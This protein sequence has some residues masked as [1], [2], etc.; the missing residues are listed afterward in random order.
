MSLE[1]INR[2]HIFI[3]A[4]GQKTVGNPK[5][6]IGWGIV[7]FIDVLGFSAEVLSSWSEEE[8]S[9]LARIRRIK[10]AASRIPDAGMVANFP[11]KAQT[12]YSESEYRARVHTVSDSIVVCSALPPNLKDLYNIT[13]ALSVVSY[14]IQM[15]WIA[16]IHEGYTIRG[17]IELSKIYWSETE[18][19]GPAFVSA[20]CLESKI[21]HESRVIL[22]PLLLHN[23]LKKINDDWSDWPSSKWLSVSHDDLIEISPHHLKDDLNAN[24]EGLEKLQ[25]NAGRN[26]EKYNHI[27]EILRAGCFR[28]ASIEDL[29]KGEVES[30]KQFRP[31][32]EKLITK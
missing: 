19:I 14:G 7:G 4:N 23:L 27:L 18:T 6:F 17:A 2:S 13:M 1:G 20:Y 5:I 8:E 22:G 15:A 26:A 28:K 24:L 25:K 21:V 11:G 3:D 12:D 30:W 16:A 29:K 32:Y 9:P 31:T 10:D